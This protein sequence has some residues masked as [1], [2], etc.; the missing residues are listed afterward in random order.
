MKKTEADFKL[1][2]KITQDSAE[3]PEASPKYTYGSGSENR[4]FYS[5]DDEDRKP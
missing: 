5:L 2:K 3:F 4:F 1:A